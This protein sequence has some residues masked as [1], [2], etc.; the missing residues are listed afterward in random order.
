MPHNTVSKA[1]LHGKPEYKY[2]GS[3][4]S[5]QSTYG[6]VWLVRIDHTVSGMPRHRLSGLKSSSSIQSSATAALDA[7]L[8]IISFRQIQ[9]G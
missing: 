8:A 4:Y 2:G 5:V 3:T 1:E 6:V 7:K 9:I